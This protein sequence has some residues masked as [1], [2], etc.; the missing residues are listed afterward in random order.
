LSALAVI[1]CPPSHNVI[2]IELHEKILRKYHLER[3]G[4]FL[5]DLK[6]TLRRKRLMAATTKTSETRSHRK[7]ETFFFSVIPRR[8]FKFLFHLNHFVGEHSRAILPLELVPKYYTIPIMLLIM[9]NNYCAKQMYVS[10]NAA[11]QVQVYRILF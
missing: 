8:L 11:V 7:P 2:N 10:N 3:I 6:H 9:T 4:C 1:R 5:N